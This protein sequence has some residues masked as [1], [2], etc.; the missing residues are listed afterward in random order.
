MAG[1]PFMCCPSTFHSRFQVLLSV[2]SG[3]L[4]SPLCVPAGVDVHSTS[5]AI[6]AQRALMWACWG[7]EAS[8]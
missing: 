1:L 4:C 2:A 8:R 7:D 3:S 6:T 5:M